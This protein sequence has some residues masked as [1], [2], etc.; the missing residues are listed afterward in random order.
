MIIAALESSD[1]LKTISLSLQKYVFL[2]STLFLFE[3]WKEK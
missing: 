1:A 3:K 2:V